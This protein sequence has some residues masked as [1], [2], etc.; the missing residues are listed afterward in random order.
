MI[1]R[2]K[3]KKHRVTASVDPNNGSSIRL[4]EKLGFRKEAH[5]IKSFYMNDQWYDD[6]IYSILEEEWDI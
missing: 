1:I 5:F 2:L 4:L 3:L 6:C